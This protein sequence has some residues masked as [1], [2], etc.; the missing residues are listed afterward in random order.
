MKDKIRYMMSHRW[1]MIMSL[2]FI[3]CLL[4]FSPARAQEE[5]EEIVE[6]KHSVTTNSF[7]ANWFVQAN[8]TA[9]NFWGSQENSAFKLKQ[10]FKDYRSQRGMSIAVGK[11][12]T[13]GIGLRTKMN[14]FWGRSVISKD[15]ETNK[16]NYWTL[17]EQVLL[18]VTNMLMGYNEE[19]VW[20]VIPYFGG[21]IARNMSYNCYSM[22][23]NIGLLNTIRINKRW[24]ANIDINYGAY[25][26]DF[27]GFPEKGATQHA[28]KN[29][30]RVINFEVGLT[31]RLGNHTWK[32]STD[33]EAMRAMSQGEIDA[34]NAQLKDAYEEIERLNK[35]ANKQ[36]NE[37]ENDTFLN[38][39]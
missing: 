9:S 17:N 18:N 38:Q 3:I 5:E 33:V 21:G 6:A 1:L 15:K 31:Y 13:P 30:D 34:L 14:G 29:K 19:R 39:E 12:F 11:W 4:S 32:G 20:N 23:L 2:S 10:V 25:E 27:D 26:P 7:W 22:G 8:F 36:E 16:S 28:L 35:H 37:V 24:A